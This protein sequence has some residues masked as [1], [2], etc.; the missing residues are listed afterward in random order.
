MIFG[1]HLWDWR[2][3]RAS[4]RPRLQVVQGSFA[5]VVAAGSVRRCPRRTGGWTRARPTKC[6]GRATSPLTFSTTLCTTPPV[7]PPDQGRKG[8]RPGYWGRR[9][10]RRGLVPQPPAAPPPFFATPPSVPGR[11][12]PGHTPAVTGTRPGCTGRSGSSR[13]TP[14]QSRS[15]PWVGP[16]PPVLARSALAVGARSEGRGRPRDGGHEPGRSGF[17]PPARAPRP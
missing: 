9:S 16:A 3:P 4:A 2:E 13:R 15:S 11:P 17:L 6:G 8:D 5:L 1:V 10:L 12:L 14:S 7:S